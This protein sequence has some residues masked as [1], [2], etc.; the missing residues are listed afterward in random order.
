M[1]DL[2]VVFYSKFTFVHHIEIIT[3]GAFKMLGF[4]SRSLNKFKKAETYM[5][6]YN[7]YVRS[8]LEYGSTIWCPYYDNHNNAL[9]RV[10]R[11]FTRSIYKKFHYPKEEYSNR[12]IRL[13]MISLE[14]RRIRIDELY[15]YNL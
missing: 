5:T 2:G 11:R 6:L 13:N 9:E 3:K 10:Q 12:L 4:I 15:I 14:H 8:A 1:R 7:L